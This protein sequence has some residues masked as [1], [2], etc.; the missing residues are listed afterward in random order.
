MP[1][2]PGAALSVTRGSWRTLARNTLVGLIALLSILP[3][4]WKAHLATTGA[5]HDCVHI[6]AFFLLALLS[7][8]RNA[9]LK[10]VLL[11]C[12]LLA[13]FGVVL[14]FLQTRI[15]HIRLEV[16]DILDDCAGLFLGVVTSTMLR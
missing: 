9:A 6:A 4:H 3:G 13:L 15:F 5:L 7:I 8:K 16:S 2:A 11:T 12:A 14:E 10:K 1:T